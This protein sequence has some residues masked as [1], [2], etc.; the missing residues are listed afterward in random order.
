MSSPPAQP[1]HTRYSVRW[2]ARLD[3]E[4]HA[5][6]EELARTFHRKRSAILRHVMQWG[7][8][9]SEGWTI[10]R[11]PV[12]AV[13]PV[14]VLLEPELLQQ[15]WDA[16]AA[17]HASVA[18][19]MRQA[20]RNVT[21]ADF[22]A[23]WLAGETARRSHESGHYRRRFMLRLDDETSHEL[24]TL[25]RTFDRPAAEVIPQLIGQAPPEDF[26]TSWHLAVER[27]PHAHKK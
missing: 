2:Q 9:H 25:I 17:H 23:R 6:L 24:E 20:M 11:H 27:R 4:T 13:P 18:A 21:M 15:M 22:P 1:R 8:R 16:A 14:P 26:P 7:L 12:V 19:W 10:D 5:K 3:P